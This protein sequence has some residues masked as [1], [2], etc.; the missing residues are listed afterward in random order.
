MDVI[1]LGPGSGAEL[2]GVTLADH[3]VADDTAQCRGVHAASSST[4]S[5]CFATRR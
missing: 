3:W 5:W 2:R 4:P 1:P